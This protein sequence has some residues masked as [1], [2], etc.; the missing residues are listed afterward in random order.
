MTKKTLL[1]L[2]M[3]LL[4]FGCH[5]PGAYA[6]PLD[7]DLYKKPGATRD[8]VKKAIKACRAKYDVPRDRPIEQ[9]NNGVFK[10][11]F[12]MED[13]GYFR[14]DGIT[15]LKSCKN[16]ADT[17]LPVCIARGAYK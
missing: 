3:P 1:I 4:L 2:L 17:P 12:C 15:A 14:D 6:P 11:A 7:E 5:L 13:K 10:V 8:D 9:Q 16:W